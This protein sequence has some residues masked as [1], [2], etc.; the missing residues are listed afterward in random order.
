MD[1]F[2]RTSYTSRTQTPSAMRHTKVREV[3][4]VRVKKYKRQYIWPINSAQ[5][6]TGAVQS[7]SNF[8]REA[9][10]RNYSMSK[11][12]QEGTGENPHAGNCSKVLSL[13][14]FNACR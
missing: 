9:T 5:W 3:E 1:K 10:E 12:R 2:T 13:D 6:P 4:D 14:T 7:T 8:R 11:F